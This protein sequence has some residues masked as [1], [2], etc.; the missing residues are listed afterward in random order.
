MKSGD[1]Y[2]LKKVIPF[3]NKIKVKTDKYIERG[4]Y[5]KAMDGVSVA[6]DVL[7]ETNQYLLDP[8]LEKQIVKIAEHFAFS[9]ETKPNGKKILFYDGFGL[10]NRGLAKIYLK[11]LVKRY[12]VIYCT[13]KRYKENVPEILSILGEKS[14]KYFIDEK[15]YGRKVKTVSEIIKKENPSDMF[16]YVFPSDV[17]AI[18]AFTAYKG[19]GKRYLI[20]LTDHAFWLGNN[21]F[22]TLIE[23][24]DYGGY[25]SF[26]DRKVDKDKIVKI[27]MYPEIN[28]NN[29]FAGFPFPFDEKKQKLFFS[30]GALYKTEGK[31]GEYY[32]L[33]DRLLEK[34]PSTVFWYA[35]T[36]DDAGLKTLKAK[37]PDRVYHTAE[38]KDLYAILSKCAFYLSTYPICGNLMTQYAAAAGVVPLTLKNGND[39]SGSLKNQDKL[40]FE[41]EDEDALIFEAEKLVTDDVYLESKKTEFIDSVFKKEDFEL[42]L[43]DLVEKNV[44]TFGITT[45][46][47]KDDFNTVYLER[48]K[49]GLIACCVAKPGRKSIFD[50]PVYYLGGCMIKA[51]RKIFDKK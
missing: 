41:F 47:K 50:Y 14:K 45:D 11:C 27:P 1:R 36:G 6:A 28:M 38:R 51:F 16:I 46:F 4:K 42:A 30:G 23:F 19:A 18:T 10:D 8:A 12:E 25:L 31:N 15:E 34:L 3:I 40:G 43:F 33:L 26:S 24:R 21:S 29:E 2:Y 20:N 17:A 44:K 7:Y 9:P 39:G 32:K 37:F 35:G 49:F 13:L 48:V 22:D 5:D